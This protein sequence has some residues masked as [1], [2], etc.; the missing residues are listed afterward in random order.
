M[1]TYSPSTDFPCYDYVYVLV[2][3]RYDIEEK[4]KS[5]I[6]CDICIPRGRFDRGGDIGNGQPCLCGATTPAVSRPTETRSRSTSLNR[7]CRG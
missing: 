5:W 4:K 2:P 7:H 6:K 1:Y 3:R